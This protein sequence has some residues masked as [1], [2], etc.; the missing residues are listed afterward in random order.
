MSVDN[1]SDTIAGHPLFA[2]VSDDVLN[3]ISGTA[4]VYSYKLGESILRL[5][6]DG[7]GFYVIEQ[8]KVRIV[9]DSGEGK[10]ITLALLKEGDSFGERSLLHDAKVSATVRAASNVVVTRIGADAFKSILE[11]RP[12]LRAQL[13]SAAAKQDEF[14][15]LKTQNLL[16]AL[17][18][19]EVQA[20]VGVVQ[21][22]TLSDGE[23]LFHEGDPGD[24]LYLVKS[25]SLKIVKESAGGKVLGFKKEGTALGEM[26]LVFNEPRSAGAVADGETV[27]LSLSRAD[28]EKAVGTNTNIQDM[29]ADQASRH[30]KQQQTLISA[31][32]AAKSTSSRASRAAKKRSRIEVS[33]IKVGHWLLPMSVSM[34]TTDAPELA[35]L[36]CLAMAGAFY[37]KPVPLEKL[38]ERQIEYGLPDDLNSLSRK[39]E[40]AGYVTRLMKVEKETLPAIQLPA[41]V[42]LVDGTLAMVFKIT[43]TSVCL[44]NPLEGYQEIDRQTFLKEWDGQILSISYAPDFGAVGQNVTKLYAQFLPILHPYWP[45]VGRLVAVIVL[46]NV[47]GLMPP[48]FTKI[49]IDDVLVV[50][51]WDLLYVMLVAILVA[52]LLAMV[53]GAV[54]EFLT[55]HLMR[56]LSNSLF[57]RFFGHVMSLPVS[58]LHKWDTGAITARFEENEKILETAS[59]GG[60]TVLMN[61]I[62]IVI[63]TPILFIM[64]PRLAAL[65]LFFSLCMAAITITCAPKMRRFERESFEIGAQRESHVIEVVKGIGT[66]KALAQEKDF[67]R[68]GLDKFRAEQ[69]IDYRSEMFDNKMELAIEFCDQAA[70][71]L[72]LG[73]GAYFVL[74]GSLSAG[75]L[76]AFTGI[77]NQVTDPVEEL[78]DFYDEYLEL[79]IALERINDILSSPREPLNSEVICPP[80]KGHLRFENFSF[81]YTEDGPWILKDINLDIKAGQKV[82]FVGRSGSGKSTLARTVNR[83]LVPTEGKIYIDDIDISR[84]DV[85]SLR[86]KI[87][88]VEQSPFI[89]SGT[90]RDNISIAQ[91]SL[92]LEAVVSAA[93]LAG[94]H[95]FVDQ[96]PMRYDTRIGEGGRSLSGGQSQRLIIARALAADPNILILDEATSALDTE[97]ERVIQRNL[98]K[99]MKDRTSLVIAHRLSTIR[100]ADLIV[101]LDEGRIAEQGSHDELMKKKGL[102]HYLATRSV[103]TADA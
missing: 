77:A 97:S 2:G 24:C 18:P 21:R 42:Q 6:D 14:N 30:L 51:D 89:F 33:K 28:F 1:I 56:R 65:V 22:R 63:Y 59:N 58:T 10:P 54:R 50:G 60:L 80:L 46:L 98:D 39:A 53:T 99:I 62:N 13:E 5:G 49:L 17:K 103:A 25:G 81:K 95:E 29:L 38:E 66:V 88:V 43:K 55:L 34:A 15:F 71:I 11:Q 67:S 47:M 87:G 41:V 64:E 68:K 16:A 74:E 27:V 45:L 93:T 3:L 75:L 100:N 92:P 8:G 73:L 78:A 20:L 12:E 23:A 76:I 102:Y 90:I 96:F 70:D 57:V 84:V 37:K 35:G 69:E 79:K 31:P 7:D 40:G 9:D 86:Q 19:K 83:L 52:A 72:V 26:A 101:V 36:A 4:A 32:P 44:A 82:A 94:V 48:L 91:P 61:S 85:T